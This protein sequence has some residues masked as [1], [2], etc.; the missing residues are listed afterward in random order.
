[1][2]SRILVIDVQVPLRDAITMEWDYDLEMFGDKKPSFILNNETNKLVPENLDEWVY[3]INFNIYGDEEQIGYLSSPTGNCEEF[4][5]DEDTVLNSLVGV[6]FLTDLY[7]YHLDIEKLFQDL[8]K[9]P[10]IVSEA[11]AQISNIVF[12]DKL[13]GKDK[14]EIIIE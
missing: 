8:C 13:N 4:L 9:Y 12:S 10:F 11:Y 2:N 14:I 5:I 1:M 3:N 7:G 6:P